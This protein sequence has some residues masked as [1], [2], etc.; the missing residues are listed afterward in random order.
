M[1][2]MTDAKVEQ[3]DSNANITTILQI[4]VEPVLGFNVIDYWKHR[5]KE[6]TFCKRRKREKNQCSP[7]I[8]ILPP[9]VFDLTRVSCLMSQCPSLPAWA[10]PLLRWVFCED[11][12]ICWSICSRSL[13][14]VVY[15]CSRRKLKAFW[16]L[17]FCV[18]QFV[19]SGNGVF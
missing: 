18:A 13:E 1:R 12:I 6:I 5:I 3:V 4:W 7:L 10:F 2:V 16:N 15:V 14:C 8:P 19:Q 11:N 9:I 17:C